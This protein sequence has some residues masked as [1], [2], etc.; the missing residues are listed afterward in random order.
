MAVVT[1]SVTLKQATA[2]AWLDQ[3]SVGSGN[4]TLALYTSPKPASPADAAT[5]TLLGTGTASLPIGSI[6]TSGQAVSIEFD[7]IAQDASADATG[8]AAWL[9]FYDENGDPILDV[10]VT[11]T[12]GTGAFKMNT[13]NVVAGGPIAFTKCEITF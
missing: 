5:G 13:T 12:A 6:V 10:D 4:V 8:I 11:S 1:P 3:F 7:A 2:Q 9:R